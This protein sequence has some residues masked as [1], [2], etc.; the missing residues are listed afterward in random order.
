MVGT[1][2]NSTA[3]REFLIPFHGRKKGGEGTGVEKVS[4]FFPQ[5]SSAMFRAEQKKRLKVPSRGCFCFCL[6][7]VGFD[8][9]LIMKAR[10]LPSFPLHNFH[11]FFVQSTEFACKHSTTGPKARSYKGHPP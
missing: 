3:K 6:G 7:Q 9:H 4:S 5:V 2:P 8:V 10:I 11:T 1:L